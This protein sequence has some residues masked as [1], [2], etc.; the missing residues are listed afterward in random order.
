MDLTVYAISIG[1]IKS[2]NAE[3]HPFLKSLYCILTPVASL[4]LTVNYLL[5]FPHAVV[6]V[7]AASYLSSSDIVHDSCG[8]FDWCHVLSTL[9]KWTTAHVSS[10]YLVAALLSWRTLMKFCWR[11]MIKSSYSTGLAVWLRVLGCV[12]CHQRIK[13]SCKIG[14]YLLC[15]QSSDLICFYT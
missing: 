12:L 5:S 11:M 15:V 13:C 14:C 9:W 6:C 3:V 10:F 1:T 7:R 4:R 2:F 8:V